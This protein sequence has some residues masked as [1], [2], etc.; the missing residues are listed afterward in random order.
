MTKLLFVFSLLA[1]RRVVPR[2]AKINVL[3]YDNKLLLQARKIHRSL[4][5]DRLDGA[6]LEPKY[7]KRKL[8]LLEEHHPT[9][10]PILPLGPAN[11]Q[12]VYFFY[13]QH[14]NNHMKSNQPFPYG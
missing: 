8:Y 12:G 6:V 2:T 14:V 3:S 11:R 4:P 7:T 13:V 1:T 10:S 9:V 5:C